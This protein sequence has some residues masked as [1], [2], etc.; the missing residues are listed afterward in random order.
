MLTPTIPDHSV[1]VRDRSRTLLREIGRV[2]KVA[3]VG[4]FLDFDV[5]SVLILLFHYILHI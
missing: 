1:Q 2:R 3:K 4:G 5:L